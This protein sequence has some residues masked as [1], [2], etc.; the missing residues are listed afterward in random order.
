MTFTVVQKLILY[1]LY[2]NLFIKCNNLKQKF[3]NNILLL[4]SSYSAVTNKNINDD[5]IQYWSFS[6]NFVNNLI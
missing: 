2:Y 6:I 4:L 5:A 3:D 1:I